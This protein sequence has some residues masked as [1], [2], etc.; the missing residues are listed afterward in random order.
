MKCHY[1]VL[2]IPRDA[3]NDDI[4]RAYHKLALKWHPDKNIDSQQEAKIQFQLIQ[5][6]YEVL[7]N[8]RER[9]WYDSHRDDI[10]LSSAGD[11]DYKDNVLNLFK[12]FSTS[13]FNGYG[14][15][16]NGFYTIYRRVFEK[17][18]TEDAPWVKG[19][20]DD[21][22]PGFGDS[23]TTYE[24]LC[25]FY[26]YWRAYN[27]KR[28]Y[29]W[30]DVFNL[31]DAPNRQGARLMER[32][33]KRIREKA[34]RERNEQVRSLVEFIKRRDKRISKFSKLLE[35]KAEENKR[36]SQEHK[37]QQILK[38]QKELQEQKEPEWSKFSNI[39]P[40][41]NNIEAAITA[42]F[43]K[44]SSDEESENSLYCVA[45]TK[46]F[47]THKAFSNHENSKK[48]KDNILVMKASM[49][50]D[51]LLFDSEENEND[52]SEDINLL[53]TGTK[54]ATGP[55][56]PDFLLNVPT[57]SK[58]NE[59][60]T[61]TSDEELISDSDLN[62]S[63]R[64]ADNIKIPNN[65]TFAKSA[66]DGGYILD[67]SDIQTKEDGYDSDTPNE[68]LFSG[69]E[70]EISAKSKKQKK[71]KNKNIQTPILE[72]SDDENRETDL[73]QGLS[74]KQ[75]KKQHKERVL[76][77]KLSSNTKSETSKSNVNIKKN[78]EKSTSSSSERNQDKVNESE[79]SPQETISPLPEK[80]KGKKAKELRKAQRQAAGEARETND[81]IRKVS[82]NTD[83]DQSCEH[84]CATCKQQFPS[85]NKLFEHLR[86]T[87][88]SVY[89]PVQE[90]VDRIIKQKNK[91]F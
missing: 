21:E 12:Y 42:E 1:E 24:S 64:K 81:R 78:P 74:K 32:E 77:D 88:H 70:D 71:K 82:Q 47:K 52:D 76:L 89:K 66:T 40:E 28:S 19:D 8:A 87:K 60:E 84:I 34:K 33:N 15:D 61:K 80:K 45:C 44:E 10:V 11:E 26:A 14:D 29:A 91:N 56:I 46:I 31:T 16:E 90:L 2:E 65:K 49:N 37:K 86:M 20:S 73:L 53:P 51:D 38:R 41:L 72:D 55:E 4:K 36:K 22:I 18:A 13:C 7:S 48:H 39:Q 54:F 35:L 3:T 25:R 17:L 57:N 58:D 50:E 27:T 79:E 5:Q 23:T 67:H 68:E 6:A 69:H 59:N 75:R 30:L 83:I 85:K 62:S 9:K 63:E 43:G